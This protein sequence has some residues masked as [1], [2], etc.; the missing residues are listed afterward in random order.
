MWNNRL[1][2]VSF[3]VPYPPDFGGAVD[4][5]YRL[6]SLSE[7]GVK[8]C[9]H[10]FK[11]NRDEHPELEKLC[12]KVTYYK[13]DRSFLDGLH[14][15][16]YIVRSRRSQSLVQ[17][18]V[19]SNAPVLF[20]GIHTTYPLKSGKLE[21]IRTLVRMHNVEQDYYRGLSKTEPNV[22]KRVYY[23][24]EAAKL[25]RYQRILKKC[26]RVLSISPSDKSYF[27]RELGVES[28][29][30]PAFHPNDRVHQLKKKG[31]F[32]LFHGDLS[33]RDNRKAAHFL[34]DVFRKIDIPL[35]IAGRTQDKKLLAKAELAKNIQFIHLDNQDQLDDLIQRAHINV[36]WSSNPA[37]IKI[38]MINA[39]FKGRFCLANSPVVGGSGLGELCEIADDEK[40]LI[41][42][43]I[44][45]MD[46]EF[47]D[48]HFKIRKQKLAVYDNRRN[49]DLLLELLSS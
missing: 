31:Y 1:N 18:L 2:I 4:V 27:D 7:A 35:I 24:I 48:D 39:L 44:Q 33:I 41:Y 14:L 16:P 36:L 11:Y 3:N 43:L 21:G 42:K 10:T 32:A 34:A 19:D 8:I 17:N 38:K 28:L 20:E 30:L 25:K 29:F 9:L 15:T 6:K 49:T 40:T 26:D 45:L 22:L 23:W 5:Y 13:R 47:S 12:E 46:Q 37:G